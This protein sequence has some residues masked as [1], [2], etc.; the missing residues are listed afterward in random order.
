[1]TEV[2]IDSTGKSRCDYQMLKGEWQDYEPPWHT[3]QIINALVEAPC[4][5]E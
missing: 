4:D 5:R 3:G 2:L 1:M